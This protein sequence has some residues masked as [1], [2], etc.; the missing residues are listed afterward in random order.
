MTKAFKAHLNW[1]ELE[2]IAISFASFLAV[3]L[4]ASEVAH[5]VWAGDLQRDT[6]LALGMA[7]ARSFVKFMYLRL[8]D[9]TIKKP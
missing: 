5:R 6:L 7:V 8:K 9:L 4:A 3:D 2:S 1:K